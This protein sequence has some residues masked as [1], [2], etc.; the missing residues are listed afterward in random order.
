MEASPKLAKNRR[1]AHFN[2]LSKYI[3]F[4]LSIDSDKTEY[5]ASIY[6]F[7][8]V[9]F[10]LIHQLISTRSLK[11]GHSVGNS[12]EYLQKQSRLISVARPN[13]LI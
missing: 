6:R 12:T 1:Y 5:P 9:Y 3:S 8:G 11:S 2:T 13:N 10:Q 4:L 7:M